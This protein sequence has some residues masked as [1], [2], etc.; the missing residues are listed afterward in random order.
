MEL[1][2]LGSG[3]TVAIVNKPLVEP[4]DGGTDPCGQETGMA[5]ATDVSLLF[6]ISSFLLA[7]RCTFT[8][9]SRPRLAVPEL[10]VLHSKPS[11][12]SQLI[13][14]RMTSLVAFIFRYG[15]LIRGEV[16]A[17]RLR[18]KS[19]PVIK[20]LAA[21]LIHILWIKINICSA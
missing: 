10:P 4:L 18:E 14:R 21:C 15:L 17:T 16:I 7:P 20:D 19:H 3:L 9:C 11:C 1:C 13:Y 12:P 6:L 5:H 2:C 8:G